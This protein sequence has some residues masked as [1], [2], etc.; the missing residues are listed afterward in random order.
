MT[1]AEATEQG[2]CSKI[3]QKPLPHSC[4]KKPVIIDLLPGAPYTMQSANCCKAGVLSTIAQDPTK[5]GASFQMNVGKALLLDKKGD[6]H[7]H[8]R[9]HKTK[10]DHLVIPQN[11]SLGL[12][13]YTC[14]EPRRVS[15]SKF[16]VDRGRRHTQALFTWNIT[17]SYSQTVASDT[18]TC[19]VSLSAFYNE[20]IVPCP[21]CSCACLEQPGMHCIDPDNSPIIDLPHG[22]D[23]VVPPKVMCTQHMCP[24]RVHWHVKTSYKEYWR[25]KMTVNNFNYVK[26]YSQWSL[27]VQHPNLRS[28]EQVFSFNY[29]PL[30]ERTI[31]KWI[32]FQ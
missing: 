17:C 29:K 1:G 11:F 19:C 10:I 24:I 25:V 27:V 28:V 21:K 15:P 3:K 4:K 30:N 22:E 8:D 6:R 20:T 32:L 9:K 16:D 26:N 18:P 31:S 7:K 2:D 13:G 12:P 14:A 23:Q 5:Y